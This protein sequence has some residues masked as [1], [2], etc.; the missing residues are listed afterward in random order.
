MKIAIDIET[1]ANPEMVDCMPEP[2]VAIGNLKDPEKIREKISEAKRKQVE[3]MALNPFHGRICSY[4]W[5]GET[6]G[7]YEAMDSV[8]D[9]EELRI[10]NV[11]LSQLTF[12]GNESPKIITWNGFDFDIPFIAKRCM[13]LNAP[14][15]TGFVGFK[16]FL[17][18]YDVDS[19]CDLMKEMTGWNGHLKL[20]TVSK[21][22]FGESKISVDFTKFSDLILS[23]NSSEIGIYNQKDCELTY[24][25]YER[26]IKFY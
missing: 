12:T 11:I 26:F 10:I 23:G 6:G 21:I 18:K 24:K 1:I 17:K 13:I 16:Y 2:E 20:D 8:C 9:A 5:Y 3:S 15:P 22:L 4:A 25:I 7:G 14:I 19:H